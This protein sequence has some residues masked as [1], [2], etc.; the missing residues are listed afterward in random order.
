VYSNFGIAFIRNL[1]L[2]AIVVRVSAAFHDKTGN[3]A[4]ERLN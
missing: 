4:V 1:L 2:P 3:R